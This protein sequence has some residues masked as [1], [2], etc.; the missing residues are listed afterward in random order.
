MLFTVSD[1]TIA[2]LTRLEL[3]RKRIPFIQIQ[4]GQV[5]TGLYPVSKPTLG[6]DHGA[7]II[8]VFQSMSM[9]RHPSFHFPW[10]TQ[11]EGIIGN[12]AS[13]D[14]SSSNEG[15]APNCYPADNS[16]ICSNGCSFLDESTLI[17]RLATHFRTR[18]TH[19]GQDTGG[20]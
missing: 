19:I 1:F 2:L 17:N 16:G 9:A 14:R 15:I 3:F 20:A 10:N 4:T 7:L 18:I 11:H 6:T 13:H 8:W 12:A 5:A